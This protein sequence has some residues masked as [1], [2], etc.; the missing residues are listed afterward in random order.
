MCQVP[1]NSQANIPVELYV[2]FMTGKYTEF[3]QH[4]PFCWI[5]ETPK[6]LSQTSISVRTV[7]RVP[8]VASSHQD[9]RP[10]APVIRDEVY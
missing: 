2:K 3:N 1:E 6:T 8:V 4:M 9:S 10:A 7:H 5:S